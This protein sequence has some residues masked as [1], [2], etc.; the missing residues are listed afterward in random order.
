M[1]QREGGSEAERLLALSE[2][3]LLSASA[4][5]EL[6]GICEDARARFG[7]AAALVTL[8]AAERLH[9]KAGAPEDRM[10]RAIAFCDHTI[11]SDDVFVVPDLSRDPRFAESPLVAA[12]PFWRFY[13]GAPLTYLPGVRLGAFCLLDGRPRAFSPGDQAELAEMADRVVAVIA[14]AGFP[15]PRKLAAD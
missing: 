11:R 14:R 6:D 3:G 9:I 10:P 7:V 4:P 2:T 13:A 1:G 8:V 5:A 12:A 15:D